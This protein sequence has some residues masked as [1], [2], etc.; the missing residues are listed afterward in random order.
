MIVAASATLT[1][2]NDE[3]FVKPPEIID[4]EPSEPDPDQPVYTDSLILLNV[5]YDESTIKLTDETAP[6]K[7]RQHFNFVGISGDAIVYYNNY[8]NSL[9]SLRTVDA[10]KLPWA[11]RQPSFPI[12][13]IDLEDMS[14]GLYGVAIPFRTGM[15][16]L[17]YQYMP[18]KEEVC[19]IE[20]DSR[21]SAEIITTRR[22]VVAQAHIEYALK[23]NPDK[24]AGSTD[25][26]VNVWQP[27]DI[28][29]EWSDVTPI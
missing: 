29:V 7:D 19:H 11:Q 26:I 14:V 22:R 21:I 12:P 2:C 28:T 23:D 10:P 3:V 17:P 18:G 6:V 8:N 27:V 9:V 25:V 20:A 16:S 4:P 13:T 24:V 15:S 1:A 5:R